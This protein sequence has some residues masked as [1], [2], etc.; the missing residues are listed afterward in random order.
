MPDVFAAAVTAN[1]ADPTAVTAPEQLAALQLLFSPDFARLA[2]SVPPLDTS[3]AAT[4]AWYSSSV[5]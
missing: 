1:A 3:A 2:E 4:A 5:R